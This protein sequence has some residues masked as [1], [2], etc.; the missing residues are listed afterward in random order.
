MLKH[1]V[2][3]PSVES[4]GENAF[5][6]CSALQSVSLPEGLKFIDKYSFANC[7]ALE[8]ISIPGSTTQIG[9]GAFYK[10]ARL[11]DVKFNEGLISI[12]RD[13]FMSCE[14]INNLIL[15]NS[16]KT[17][18]ERCFEGCKSFSSLT[19]PASVDTIRERAFENCLSLK[20]LFIED[21]ERTLTYF[22]Y[23]RT[24]HEDLAPINYHLGLFRRDPLEKI[25]LG[26]NIV[27]GE[28]SVV[29]LFSKFETLRELTIGDN[30]TKINYYMFSSC[31]S[32]EDIKWNKNL[33]IIK[34]GAFENCE[35]LSEL[36]LPEGI[37]YIGEAAFQNCK[38]AKTL[39]LPT[40]ISVIQKNTFYGCASVESLTI[41]ANIDSLKLSCFNGCTSLKELIIEDSE[42]ELFLDGVYNSKWNTHNAI[43]LSQPIEYAYIG[44]NLTST[45][46]FGT[47][48]SDGSLKSVIISDYVTEIGEQSFCSDVTNVRM[49][50]NVQ[51]IGTAAFMNCKELTEIELSQSLETIGN[52]GFA[53]SALKEI[54]LPQSLKTLGQNAFYLCDSLSYI[55]FGDEIISIG[56][57]AFYG[58][59]K[60]T[61]L[62]LPD[63]IKEI[64]RA[65]FSGNDSGLNNIYCE[66]IDPINAP[67]IFNSKIYG[68]A[69]LH[70]PS[71]TLKAYQATEPWCNFINIVE[72]V[73]T[74]I[75]DINA[76]NKKLM[77]SV[78]NGIISITDPK[79]SPANIDIYDLTGKCVY[80]GRTTTVDN[81]PKGAYIIHSASQV[82]KVIL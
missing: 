71:N 31:K 22:G 30:V 29:S 56:E 35:L 44:R 5:A 33:K 14:S 54:I 21:S 49:G 80:R 81:L 1:I 53:Y 15:P 61:E 46:R 42:K 72:D 40:A 17:I 65:A 82:T 36:N 34:N 75:D 58:C 60:L 8:S 11:T 27:E 64:G 59:S 19:I 23:N 51:H 76:D 43:F 3:P 77:I 55:T 74:G 9:R 48:I 20:D 37:R 39:K 78:E 18:G 66:W 7:V 63:S 32:L 52:Y 41:P 67:H 47:P 50:N 79:G 45:Y 6:D 10:C 38:S 24:Q 69:T 2:I 12:G 62:R 28:D 25:H 57:S 4:I 73:S 70:I 16:L 13:A 68:T 26:R